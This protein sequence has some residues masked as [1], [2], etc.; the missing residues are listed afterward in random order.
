MTFNTDELTSEDERPRTIII[1]GDKVEVPADCEDFLAF[2]KAET[3]RRGIVTFAAFQD[4]TELTSM[5]DLTDAFEEGQT[6]E[7][8][9]YSKP[10]LSN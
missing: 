9:T 5:E 6:I 8:R 2:L 4:G 3:K 7:V 1:N 10:G